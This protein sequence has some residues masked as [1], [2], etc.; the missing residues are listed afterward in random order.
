MEGITFEVA[1]K[2]IPQAPSDYL[3]Q[4]GILG[5]RQGAT[6]VPHVLT[7]V[8]QTLGRSKRGKL[9]YASVRT[10]RSKQRPWSEIDPQE[11]SI[12][13]HWIKALID[14]NAIVPFAIVTDAAKQ[15]IIP[16]AKGKQGGLM[17]DPNTAS[18]FW[19]S[20][21]AIYQEHKGAGKNTPPDL[22]RQI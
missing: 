13:A 5:F 20:L 16:L 8:G 17:K 4:R 12:P 22:I 21:E 7:I 9:S 14:S 19:S 15:A 2:R 18:E 11:G 6:I 1:P 3:G 10:I